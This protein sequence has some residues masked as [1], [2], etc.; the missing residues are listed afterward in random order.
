MLPSDSNVLMPHSPQSPPLSFDN[1]FDT[2]HTRG[3]HP[4]LPLSRLHP[5]EHVNRIRWRRG[6]LMRHWYGLM[7]S[8][9]TGS[10]RGS[11]LVHGAAPDRLLRWYCTSMSSG[12]ASG[13]DVKRQTGCQTR[14]PTSR[15]SRRNR[16]EGIGFAWFQHFASSRVFCI[17]W[18]TEGQGDR[19]IGAISCKLHLP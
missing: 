15:E 7:T 8:G 16:R 6:R 13:T 17:R 3:E 10:G 5:T 9:K 11:L 12:P 2:L 18:G 1:A 4:R 14:Q 19:L